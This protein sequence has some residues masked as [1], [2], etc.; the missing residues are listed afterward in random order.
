MQMIAATDP[1]TRSADLVA[2]NV[3]KFEDLFPEA[4]AEGKIDVDVL[5]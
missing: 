2:E 4:F 5:R 1:E 3:A